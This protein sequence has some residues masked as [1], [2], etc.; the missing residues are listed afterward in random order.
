MAGRAAAWIAMARLPFHPMAF[1]A[2]SVGAAAAYNS[3]G[4]FDPAVFL[5]GYLV[6]FLIELAT[7]FCNEVYDYETDRLNEN[8]STFTGGSRVLVE[9]RLGIAEA[10][11]SVHMLLV[12]S[13]LTTLAL[14]RINCPVAAVPVLAAVSLGVCLGIGYTAPPLK[15]SYRGLGEFVVALTHSLYLVLCGYLFQSGSLKDPIPWLL[16]VPLFFAVFAA[17]VL[18][19][20][21]DRPSDSLAS[22]KSLSVLIG[23][24]R[25]T[26]VAACAVVL[27]AVAG[28]LLWWY[29]VLA[30]TRG[31]AMIIVVPH[32]VILVGQLGRLRKSGAFD[33]RIDPIMGSAL[34]YIVW[35]GIIPLL[36]L[37]WR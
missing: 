5:T 22:K 30:G 16:A 32:A 31:V 25:A 24:R 29:S 20:I 15:L 18:A 19:G 23:S 7:I 12:M 21:P 6:L 17:N 28:M 26:L 34:T 14:V 33:R 4:R 36:T 8:Y 37:L 9:G 1:I 35:F 27:A 11:R 3:A 2:Y 10:K 13:V